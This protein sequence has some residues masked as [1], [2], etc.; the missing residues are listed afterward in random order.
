MKQAMANPAPNAPSAMQAALLNSRWSTKRGVYAGLNCL[1]A[2]ALIAAIIPLASVL[3]L[4][5]AKGTA[6]FRV[7]MLWDLPPGAGMSGGGFGNALAGT[8]LIVLLASA[9]SVPAGLGVAVYLSEFSANR[10]LARVVRFCAK[11]LSG[12]PSILAGVFVFA[13]V[14][15]TTR[16]F[17]L[18]AGG[19]SLAVLML[20]IIT[21]AG[22]EALLRVSG[23][24]REASLALGASLSQT[25]FRVV[26]PAARA[27]L[28]TAISLAVARAAGESAPLIFTALFSDY[29]LKSALEPTASL[30]VLIYNFSGMPYENQLNLAWSASLILILIV[31]LA[32]VAARFL[33]GRR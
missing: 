28:L 5:V 29:W 15:V 1:V 27:P 16:K 26:I 23:Q 7:S 4:V 14:V 10:R 25:V 22:E 6:H 30:S 13:T 21:L 33:T 24:L 19:L 20:P 12:L 3:Y 32:N 8:V 18:I 9:V 2:A 31:L 17:S 11:V